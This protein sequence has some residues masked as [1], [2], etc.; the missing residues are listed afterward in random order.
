VASDFGN[1]LS[2]GMVTPCS[3]RRFAMFSTPGYDPSYEL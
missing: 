3:F 2:A 1:V